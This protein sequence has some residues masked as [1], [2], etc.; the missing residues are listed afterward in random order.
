M[1]GQPKLRD[2]DHDQGCAGH[3]GKE[4][5][6]PDEEERADEEEKPDDEER[7]DEEEKP[8]GADLRVTS[9]RN[10][11]PRVAT[12]ICDLYALPAR[13][14]LFAALGVRKMAY[15]HIAYR[16][17]AEPPLAYPCPGGTRGLRFRV[18]AALCS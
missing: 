14:R 4:Q 2:R 13:E 10:D 11:P 16:H 7:A 6:K 12:V 15:G 1:A 3:Y 8:D 17:P 9:G 18:R 5:E